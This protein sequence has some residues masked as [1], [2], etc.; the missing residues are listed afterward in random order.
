MTMA[1]LTPSYGPDLEIFRALRRSARRY[2]PPDTKHYVV[3]PR[4]DVAEFTDAADLN[5][6]IWAEE[7]LLPPGTVSLRLIDHLLHAMRLIPPTLRLARMD[8][9]RPWPPLRGW[10]IQQLVKLEAAARVDADAVLV[11]DSDIVFI[12]QFSAATF[13]KNGAVRSFRKVDAVDIDLPLHLEWNRVARDLL[14]VAEPKPPLPDYISSLTAWD[15]R[16][17]RLLQPRIAATSERPWMTSLANLRHLS[18]W[19]L[20]GVF[21]DEVAGP[22]YSS[23][24][25]ETT[26]CHSYWDTSPL[27]ESSLDDFLSKV[28]PDDIALHIQSK[29][30]TSTA[31]REMAVQRIDELLRGDLA[32][33]RLP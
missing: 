31:V 6:V 30:T 15:P 5:C 1:L 4:R 19:T 25:A 22:A 13:V 10:V 33:P 9:R 28:S 11:V 8:F 12:R 16:V 7:D 29:S 3:V 27:N 23:F 20:Y 26:L 21:L 18:E 32:E 17:V 2:A 14:N 24:V